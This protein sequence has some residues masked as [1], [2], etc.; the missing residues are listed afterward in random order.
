MV[1]VAYQGVAGAYSQKACYELLGEDI[2]CVGL[3][4]FTAVFEAVQNGEAS[5]AMVPIENSLGG[6]IHDNFDNMF[7]YNVHIIAEYNLR[8]RHCLVALKGV[9]K[10]EVLTI[11]HHRSLPIFFPSI[12][13]TTS[14]K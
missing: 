6:S 12:L 5:Y 10:E 3:S 13:L 14:T 7:R 9:K 11:W 4:S 8:V 1:V 2:K